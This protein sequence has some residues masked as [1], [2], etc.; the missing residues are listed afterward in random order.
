MSKGKQQ[1]NKARQAGESSRPLGKWNLLRLHVAALW[2]FC[3]ALTFIPG[4]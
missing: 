2:T 3:H 1:K 4:N